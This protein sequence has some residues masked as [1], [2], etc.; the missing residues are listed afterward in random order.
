M[1]K[2]TTKKKMIKWKMEKKTNKYRNLFEFLE[3]N[4]TSKAHSRIFFVVLI[5]NLKKKNTK[6]L[7]HKLNTKKIEHFN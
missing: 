4:S 5:L 6:E 7:N 2:K 3:F 1:K